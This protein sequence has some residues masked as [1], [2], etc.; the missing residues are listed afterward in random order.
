MSGRKVTPLSL[1]QKGRQGKE[2]ALFC[3][4]NARPSLH[5]RSGVALHFDDDITRDISFE[6]SRDA[7]KDVFEE[8]PDLEDVKQ[9]L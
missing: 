4:S 8:Y 9:K 1:S 7:S 6:H 2:S 3:Y 5:I